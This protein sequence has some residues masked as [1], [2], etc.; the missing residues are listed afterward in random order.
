MKTKLCA[1]LFLLALGGGAH[2]ATLS[3]TAQA[4][5]L[6]KKIIAAYTAE[7]YTKTKKLFMEY[8]QLDTT[9][10]PPLMLVRARFHYDIGEFV[11]AYQILVDYLNIAPPDSPDYDTALEMYVGLDAKPEVTAAAARIEENRRFSA[12]FGRDASPDAINVDGITDLHFAAAANMPGL[13]KVLLDTGAEINAPTYADRE[14]LSEISRKKLRVLTKANVF[15]D[16]SSHRTGGTPLH[17]A[18]LGNARKATELLIAR[19]ADVNA[20][21]TEGE[22]PLHYAVLGNARKATEL[23]IARG[24]DVNA[25]NKDDGTP[26]HYAAL[27]NARE[28]ADLLI[29]HGADVNAKYKDG[30]TPRDMAESLGHSELAQLLR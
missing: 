4:A 2:A 13:V 22:T 12:V 7:D 8:D 29:A 26:L 23:L 20:K 19:G 28:A 10:P 16:W 5:V 25:K 6:G 21:N 24:A 18:V 9:M 11:A 3:G 17:Y 14:P 27:L 1:F 30:R 15:D